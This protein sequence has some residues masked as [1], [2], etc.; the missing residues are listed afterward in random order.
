[1][2][3]SDDEFV[4]ATYCVLLGRDPEPA[5]LRHW[6]TLLEKGLERAQFIHAVVSSAEFRSRMATVDRPSEY[7]DVDVVVPMPPHEFRLPLA[8]LSFVPTFL[9]DRIWEPHVTRYLLRELRP[10]HTFVDVGANLGYFSVICAPRVRRVIAFEPVMTT[11]RYCLGNIAL[12]HLTNVEVFP[13]GLWEENATLPMRRDPSSLMSASLAADRQTST[14]ESISCVS[15]DRLIARGDLQLSSLDVMKMDIEGAEV[16][17]L[18]GMRETA[19]RF[20]PRIILELNRP[21]LGRL[22]GTVEDVWRFFRD[23]SYKLLAFEHWKETD[24]VPVPSVERLMDLC[25]ADGLIDALAVP[26]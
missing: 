11:Y 6:S 3:A 5:G 26:E 16:S 20:R 23:L 2:I 8:D 14:G 22:G 18:R 7:R 4:T 21:A 12:N 25:P 24:P 1:M 10:S 17:A 13:F 19:M 15:L 9:K